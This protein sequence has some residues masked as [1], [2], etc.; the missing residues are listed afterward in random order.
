MH[1]SIA[2]KHQSITGRPPLGEILYPPLSMHTG[3]D[4]GRCITAR[5][6]AV[7]VHCALAVC[8]VQGCSRCSMQSLLL[9]QLTWGSGS[10]RREV[11]NAVA[12]SAPGLASAYPE[13]PGA[14]PDDYICKLRGRQLALPWE[15]FVVARDSSLSFS[16]PGDSEMKFVYSF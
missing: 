5:C 7:G 3:L 13:W 8:T 12:W 2:F 14:P 10:Q 6:S 16:T 4:T 9:L 15:F 11:M 1:Y